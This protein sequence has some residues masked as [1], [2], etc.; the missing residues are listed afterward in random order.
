[1]PRSQTVKGRKTIVPKPKNMKVPTVLPALLPEA[2]R[3]SASVWLK[4]LTSAFAAI[5]LW[6]NLTLAKKYE[7]K[8]RCR[9]N[10]IVRL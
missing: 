6:A 2:I 4:M 3:Q 5:T 7:G 1:M 9:N 10:D 8:D